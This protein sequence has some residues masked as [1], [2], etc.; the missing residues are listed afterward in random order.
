MSVM[1]RFFFAKKFPE[2]EIYA[3][4]P[5]LSNYDTLLKNTKKFKN[6]I[7]LKKGL[8]SKSGFLKI[9]DKGY[10]KWGFMTEEVG[11]KENWD[12]EVITINDIIN[13]SRF[14]EIDILKLDI[15]GAEKEIFSENFENWLGKVH[16][17]IIELHDHMKSGCSSSFYSAISKYNFIIEKSGENV[18]LRKGKIIK[19]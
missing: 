6:V 5:E 19:T 7:P 1:L 12:V 2:A 14:Q 8:W 13:M 17:L 11:Y 10:G 3:I 4:E 18:V 9:V 16:V 15:E